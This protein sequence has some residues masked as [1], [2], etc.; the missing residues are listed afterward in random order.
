MKNEKLIRQELEKVF[1]KIKYYN[2]EF[3][4]IYR[5]KNEKYNDL[6]CFADWLCVQLLH[7]RK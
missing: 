6:V 5:I 1:Q 4:Y 2:H 7:N 3:T